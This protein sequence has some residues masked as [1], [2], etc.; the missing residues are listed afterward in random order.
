MFLRDH[1]AL[2]AM[3]SGAVDQT[4][5]KGLKLLAGDYVVVNVDDHAQIL[6]P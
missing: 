1:S 2:W 6:S 5:L 4:G 3:K